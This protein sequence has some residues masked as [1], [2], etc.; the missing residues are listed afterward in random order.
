MPKH[1]KVRAKGKIGLSRYFQP[2]KEGDIIALVKEPGIKA[3][4]PKRMQ[5]ATGLVTGKRGRAYVVNVK[6]LGLSKEFSVM[7][8]HLKKITMKQ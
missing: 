1:K 5:G 6:D 7:P 4:F 3:S 2:F 8:I